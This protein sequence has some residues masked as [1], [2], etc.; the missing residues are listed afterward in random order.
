MIKMT[1]E[2]SDII[3]A[4]TVLIQLKTQIAFLEDNK[5]FLVNS[6]FNKEV[7]EILK[8]SNKKCSTLQK[9]L[10]EYVD[11]ENN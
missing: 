1:D 5:D 6:A 11:F 8:F 9:W 2:L 10:K 4:S 7:E 3:V